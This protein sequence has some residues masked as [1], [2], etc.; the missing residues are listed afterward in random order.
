MIRTA[1]EYFAIIRNAN[2]ESYQRIF[3][4]ATDEIWF[5]ILEYPEFEEHVIKNNFISAAVLAVLANSK[6]DLIRSQ[7]ADKRRLLKGTFEKLANDSLPWVR[8]RI[9]CNKKCPLETLKMLM[10]DT[11]KEVADSATEHF[12]KNRPSKTSPGS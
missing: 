5:Q 3:E 7:V 1:E 2:E 6:S 4:E 9:A 11:D 12:N 8:T 10:Q